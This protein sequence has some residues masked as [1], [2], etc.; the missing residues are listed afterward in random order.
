MRRPSMERVSFNQ[1]TLGLALR[2]RASTKPWSWWPTTRGSALAP[3]ARPFFAPYLLLDR[4]T[5]ID[6]SHSA[7]VRS[8]LV[9]AQLSL[10]WGLAG[11][12]EQRH[13]RIEPR[14]ARSLRMWCGV[15]INSVGRKR[16]TASI[17]V[18]L[19]LPFV[20]SRVQAR[21]DREGKRSPS[22]LGS[23]ARGLATSQALQAFGSRWRLRVGKGVD[24]LSIS[25]LRQVKLR[26]VTGSRM[27]AQR[28]CGR[29]GVNL[30]G[31]RN[32]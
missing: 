32:F 29:P 17:S 8:F 30:R 4:D 1:T 11:C 6:Q 3:P 10:C 22:T 18:H 16:L 13:K 24:C 7:L 25:R 26:Q 9:A 28:P 15:D 19:V 31:T 2:P 21:P 5:D 20:G 12:V 27:L 23:H 14:E